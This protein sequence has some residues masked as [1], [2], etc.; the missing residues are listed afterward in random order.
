MTTGPP[1]TGCQV[2]LIRHAQPVIDPR[3]HPS[4]FELAGEGE[5]AARRLATRID[6]RPAVVAAGAE[7]KLVSTVAPLARRWGLPVVH[8][9]DLGESRSR[10]WLD[11]EEFAQLV[12]RFLTHPDRPPAVGW[13]S[14]DRAA[15]RLLAGISGLAAE[16]E[17]PGPVVVCTG[18]RSL[19]AVLMAVGLVPR[20]RTFETW[21][22]LR[23]PELAKIR[24]DDAGRAHY[25]VRPGLAA[26]G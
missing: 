11:P 25:E 1:P 21:L 4:R 13:E 5:A 7:P 17:R 14:A 26:V 19:T 8:H 23:S 18:G 9:H 12:E 24:F 3:R 6:T 16:A 15:G 2:L 10:G 22:R 20:A